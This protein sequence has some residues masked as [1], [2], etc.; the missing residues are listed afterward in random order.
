MLKRLKTLLEAPLIATLSFIGIPLLVI[1]A[2]LD[3]AE[4]AKSL[5]IFAVIVL[6]GAWTSLNAAFAQKILWTLKG[7]RVRTFALFLLLFVTS[8]VSFSQSPHP[9]TGLQVLRND[10]LPI[11]A[12]C[13]LGMILRPKDVLRLLFCGA[14]LIG[15]LG[16]FQI[17][18]DFQGLTPSSD[19][20]QF[21]GVTFGNRGLASLFVALGIVP[22]AL[23]LK[24]Q[25]GNTKVRLLVALGLLIQCSFILLTMTRSVWF[26]TITALCVWWF[27]GRGT[28]SKVDSSNTTRI[29][30]IKRKRFFVLAGLIGFVVLLGLLALIMVSN[31]NLLILL[32]HRFSAQNWINNPRLLIWGAAF[33]QMTSASV[34]DVLFGLGPGAFQVLSMTWLSSAGEMGRYFQYA[35]NDF[36]E[37]CVEYGLVGF[38]LR[39]ALIGIGINW[40]IRFFREGYERETCI[41]CLSQCFLILVTCFFFYPL[42]LPFFSTQLIL[43]LVLVPLRRCYSKTPV[44][45]FFMRRKVL[46]LVRTFVMVTSMLLLGVIIQRARVE[47]LMREYVKERRPYIVKRYE[48]Q[49]LSQRLRYI[50]AP[51]VYYQLTVPERLKKR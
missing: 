16:I 13:F 36:L 18:F 45:P 39:I 35:H 31:E 6:F 14:T 34:T 20:G 26:G 37:I 23:L 21:P 2:F 8:F 40:L 51:Y 49:E 42:R 3:Y 10:F 33:R 19:P 48:Q 5:A 47:I 30:T 29:F 4:E 44:T 12:A 41:V 25:I 22:G 1:P 11:L 27:F 50:P 28:T 43:F 46:F 17:I 7:S 9:L 38:L 32:E 24:E 15:V